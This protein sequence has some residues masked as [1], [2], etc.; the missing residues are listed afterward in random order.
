M[1]LNRRIGIWFGL[2][3]G[4]HLNY[5]L[6]LN[7]MVFELRL[8]R[9]IGNY[10]RQN[11]AGTGV[12]R[13]ARL[14]NCGGFWTRIFAKA[15]F[16]IFFLISCS[17]IFSSFPHLNF[18]L[19]LP[20]LPYLTSPSSSSFS[21]TFQHLASLSTLI[22]LRSWPCKSSLRWP[23]IPSPAVV[24]VILIFS[25]YFRCQC[26]RGYLPLLCLRSVFLFLYANF[27][28][29]FV[30]CRAPKRSADKGTVD[31]RPREDST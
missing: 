29:R 25:L 4:L 11:A 3:F 14:C 23:S 8:N 6:D 20:S 13:Q 9:R 22:I 7:S 18:T 15:P 19:R 16:L 5:S 24:W 10:L 12:P 2:H 17:S 28:P 1:R 21:S 27:L 30:P 26:G 31:A